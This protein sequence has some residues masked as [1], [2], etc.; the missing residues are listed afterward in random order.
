MRAGMS[1]RTRLGQEDL[2]AY[3]KW[4]DTLE[5]GP[6]WYPSNLPAG[7]TPYS[8]GQLELGRAV[9]MDLGGCG[10]VGICAIPLRAVDG[11]RVAVGMDSR[12]VRSESRFSAGDGCV[13]RR[14]KLFQ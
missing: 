8:N 9:G 6:V 4:S 11:S 10:C 3:G 1:I 7:W 13:R 5:Y 12:A 2:D 14:C